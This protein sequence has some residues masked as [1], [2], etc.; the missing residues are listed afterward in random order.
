MRQDF[1]DPADWFDIQI[2]FDVVW[3]FF[4]VLHV[5][6]WDQDVLDIAAMGCKEF[7]L[8]ATHWQYF[9]TQ[10]D[11]ARHRGI[12]TDWNLCQH[13]YQ[14]C[15]HTDTSRWTIF[16]GCT[17]RYVDMNIMLVKKVLRNAKEWRT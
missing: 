3:N 14:C 10:G 17:F 5:F 1:V 15:A 9:A 16:R 7:F 2:F 6:F 8:D 4:Q 13:R 11:F 12:C